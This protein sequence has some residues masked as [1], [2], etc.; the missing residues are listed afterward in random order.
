MTLARQPAARR[1]VL[2][3]WRSLKRA[4]TALATGLA[5]Q[6]VV[7]F[8]I[9][10]GR[11]GSCGPIDYTAVFKFTLL[12][13]GIVLMNGLHI[14]QESLRITVLFFT[15]VLIYSAVIWIALTLVSWLR[16]DPVIAAK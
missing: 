15:P 10:D 4:A 1:A 2:H 13:P 7:W 14:R 5:V 3:R 16:R 12:M 11:N 6:A 8:A 9:P